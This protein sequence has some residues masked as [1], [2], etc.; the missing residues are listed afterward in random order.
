MAFGPSIKRGAQCASAHGNADFDIRR[1]FAFGRL[2]KTAHFGRQ[3]KTRIFDFALE[4][5][6]A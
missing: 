5:S 2:S 4:T 3:S 1:C 6:C